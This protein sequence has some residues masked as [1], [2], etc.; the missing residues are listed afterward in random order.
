MIV[1]YQ[2]GKLLTDKDII[3]TNE[4]NPNEVTH[5]NISGEFIALSFLPNFATGD[6][7]IYYVAQGMEL[8]LVHEI[9][10]YGVTQ[11]YVIEQEVQNN[12]MRIKNIFSSMVFLDGNPALRYCVFNKANEIENIRLNIEEILNR[13][14]FMP[15]KE[16]V[17][18]LEKID[19]WSCSVFYSTNATKVEQTTKVEQEVQRKRGKRKPI[20]CN[21]VIF[22]TTKEFAK[23][24]GTNSTYV[25]KCFSKGFTPEELYQK[26]N[27]PNYKSPVGRKTTNKKYMYAGQELTIQE[28]SELSGIDSSLIRDRLHRGWSVERAIET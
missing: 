8:Y 12:K 16:K 25:H 10:L 4:E 15:E 13:I 5:L 7:R 19:E 22:E 28:L 11:V 20:V 23:M 3:R 26:Y 2:N 27:D 9:F 18:L 6:G 21:G 1:H 17:Y 24:L 14:Q